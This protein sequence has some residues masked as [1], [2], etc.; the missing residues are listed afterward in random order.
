MSEQSPPHRKNG[1]AE[2]RAD[3]CQWAGAK[4]SLHQR[5]WIHSGVSTVYPRGS[6]CAGSKFSSH[7]Y[8]T[9]RIFRFFRAPLTRS[10]KFFYN[11]LA[12]RLTALPACVQSATCSWGNVWPIL[13]SSFRR[14]PRRLLPPLKISSA[15]PELVDGYL[16][17]DGAGPGGIVARRLTASRT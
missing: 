5:R 7:S 14:L 1:V 12:G 6:C 9:S 17:H 13:P 15:G 8:N 3:D 11:S 2:R 10:E 16:R 4:Q